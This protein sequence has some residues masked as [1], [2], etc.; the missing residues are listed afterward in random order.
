MRIISQNG[1][2]DVPYEMTA[3][4]M[5]GGTIRMNMVGDTG[6]GTIIAEYSTQEKAEKS[7]QKLHECYTGVFILDKIPSPDDIK[8]DFAHMNGF[9]EVFSSGDNISKDSIIMLSLDS[10]M[11]MNCDG[12]TLNRKSRHE[13]SGHNVSVGIFIK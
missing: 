5:D 9:I 6:K 12:I 2:I 7:M 4:H 3:F 8:K 11:R 10:R 1:M 13:Q